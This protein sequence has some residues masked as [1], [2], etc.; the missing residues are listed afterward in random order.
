M[1]DQEE[2]ILIQSVLVLTKNNIEI[3]GSCTL[4]EAP[5]TNHVYTISNTVLVS[6][7]TGDKI[8]LLFW[9]DSTSIH[10]GDPT[11]VNGILPNITPNTKPQEATASLVI[12]RITSV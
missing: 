1:L 10:L 9:A 2:Q 11:I 7:S 3:P 4:V 6:L 12:T 5:D 8:S